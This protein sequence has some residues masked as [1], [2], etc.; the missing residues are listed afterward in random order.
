MEAYDQLPQPIRQVISNAVCKI[1]PVDCLRVYRMKGQ[2]YVLAQ[3]A[4][5]ER[6]KLTEAEQAIRMALASPRIDVQR[7]LWQGSYP[8]KGQPLRRPVAY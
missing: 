7:F 4:A 2:A 6:A 1:S 3:I 5:R 8:S